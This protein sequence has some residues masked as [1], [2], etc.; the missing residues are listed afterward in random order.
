MNGTKE[1]LYVTVGEAARVTGLEN[2]TVRK[3]VEQASILCFRTPGGQRRIHL[4]SLQEYCRSALPLE[5]KPVIQKK[6]Y[7]Y[8]RVSSQKQVEDLSRQIEYLRKP[9]YTGY[10][11][12]ADVASGLNF[13]R[14]GLSTI[15]D[16]CLQGTIGE[17]IIAH[18]DRLCRFGFELIE[19]LVTKSGG[20]ITILDNSIIKTSEQELSEDILSILH[21]FSCKQMGKRSYAS[22]K[23]KDINNTNI[24]NNNSKE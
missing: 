13:K 14:K 8:A 4:E 11:T 5:E 7:I 20:K 15:L 21:V 16:A 6:N 17:I 9:E 18:R 10:T 1:K 3:M 23:I 24:S 19:Q 12:L 2:Q 22:R